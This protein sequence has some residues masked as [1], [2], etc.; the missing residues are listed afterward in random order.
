MS[1]PLTLM[2]RYPTGE[3]RESRFEGDTVRI[4]RAR[5]CELPLESGYISRF[6]ARLE[7][8]QSG[9][10]V[11]DEGSKNGVFVNGRRVSTSQPLN[12]HDMLRVG[13]H[14]VV[15]APD[16]PLDESAGRYD[17]TLVL[18]PQGLDEPAATPRPRLV[19]DAAQRAV[20][21]D[22]APPREPL[23]AREFRLL[24]TLASAAAAT[25]GYPRVTL[26]DM[27]WGPGGG[28][29]DMLDR[30]ADRLRAKIEPDPDAPRFLLDD[31]PAKVEGTPTFVGFGPRER[32]YRLNVL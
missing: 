9:W 21:I 1:E 32:G 15:F 11:I 13:D 27:L 26:V 31:E 23:S 20:V 5:E 24:D 16:V 28:D 4:G 29:G 25:R 14:T 8:T 10:E 12:P 7:R 3:E 19:L 2:V 30:L 17:R 22:G 18:P 6:H